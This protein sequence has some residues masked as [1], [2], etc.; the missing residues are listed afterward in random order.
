MKKH[1]RSRAPMRL[2]FGGGGTEIPPFV[3]QYGGST[4]STTIAVYARTSIENNDIGTIEFI[5]LDR[6]V[7]QRFSSKDFK[8]PNFSEIDSNLRLPFACVWYVIE[9]KG[10]EFTGGITLKT[11]SD[12]PQGS[13]LGASSVLTV[14]I[15]RAL[16]EFFGFHWSKTELAEIAFYI[17]RETLK[18]SGGMQDHYAAAFG[19]CNFIN[20]HPNGNVSVEPIDLNEYFKRELESSLI[21]IYTGTSRESAHII[22]DQQSAMANRDQTA[23]DSLIS[24]KEIAIEMRRS[25]RKEDIKALGS[26]L[27]DSWNLKKSTSGLIT[28]QSIDILYQR[29]LELGAY[30]GKIAGAGGGGYLVLLA[31]PENRSQILSNLV[32][33]DMVVLPVVLTG[34][35]AEA[36]E[37]KS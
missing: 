19:G 16:D 34:L 26:Q 18:L 5:S 33:D 28:N 35:G 24:M 10:A 20:Y 36:W 11:S 22:E 6:G 13:G 23:I 9:R 14:S 1:V 29:A 4:L 8:N 7:R 3:N 25:I 2:S 27:H 15:L 30:G 12:A 32:K 17:E 37:V 31:S 21:S